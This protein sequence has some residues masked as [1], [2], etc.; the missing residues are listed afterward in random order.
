[1]TNISKD[2]LWKS[3]IEDLFED[4][5]AYFFPSW[6][7]QM[8][9]FAQPVEF[10]DKELDAIFPEVSTQKRYA[11][12]LVKVF[13]KQGREQWIL[14]HIEV[15][16]YQDAQFA[17]RMFTYFYRILDRYEQQVMALA[18]LTDNNAQ[19]HPQQYLYQYEHT[20][21]SYEFPSFKV[22]QKTERSLQVPHNP[23]SVVM[24]AAKKALYKKN[25]TDAQQLIWK[26][27]LVEALKDA[28][29]SD[30]KIRRILH[31]IRYYVKFNEEESLQ[32][33]NKNIQTTFKHRKNMGIEE[34]ILQ[35]VREE[36]VEEGIH[37]GVLQTALRMK[38][39]G[40]STADI[41][42]FTGLTKAQ[43]EKLA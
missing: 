36:A 35:A 13:T 43:V 3:I 25:L 32:T 34:A 14:V 33:L 2:T 10:L 41:V 12:K 22:L 39:A 6:T 42:K 17:Q 4:F 31:F 9:N 40:V 8:A 20:K 16:G 30:D 23:F 21:C 18:I 37:K 19:Y 27:S 24:L 5:C 26:K 1:M 7:A 11:D 15:Q 29:Y 28:H 38:Q